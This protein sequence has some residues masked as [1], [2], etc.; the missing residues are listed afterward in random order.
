[1]DRSILLQ[2]FKQTFAA[3][4]EY[5]RATCI[6][7]P[8]NVHWSTPELRSAWSGWISSYETYAATALGHL[9]GAYNS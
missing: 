6:V 5:T 3:W 7:H 1:M 2:D 9:T 8:T 4:I